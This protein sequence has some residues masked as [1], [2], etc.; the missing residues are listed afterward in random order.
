MAS[1][2]VTL[3]LYAMLSEWASRK[4]CAVEDIASDMLWSA[5]DRSPERRTKHRRLTQVVKREIK[6]DTRE[7]TPTAY[8]IHS[9]G[10]S[11]LQ[12]ESFWVKE[13]SDG[14]VIFLNNPLGWREV[15]WGS[16]A[17]ITTVAYGHGW[18]S[19]V[20]INKTYS[21]IIDKNSEGNNSILVFDRLSAEAVKALGELVLE[22]EGE[23]EAPELEEPGLSSPDIEPGPII[24]PKN[25]EVEYIIMP[26]EEL[27]DE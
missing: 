4:G 9:R 22:L 21:P 17:K 19:I 25:P 23:V 13:L 20:A 1:I 11:G 14:W 5:W 15:E 3:E 18:K 26:P 2:Q 7:L 6:V 8:K 12:S 27:N 16:L 24:D 10:E